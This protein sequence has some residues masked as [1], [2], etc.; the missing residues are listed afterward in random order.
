MKWR[1]ALAAAIATACLACSGDKPANGRPEP[2]QGTVPGAAPGVRT[3]AALANGEWPMPTGDYGNLRYSPLSAINT[4]NVKN[5]HPV[6]TMSTGV[7]CF[8]SGLGGTVM[9]ALRLLSV[10]AH[11]GVES[12]TEHAANDTEH[13]EI[14]ARLHCYVAVGGIRGFE[15]DRPIAVR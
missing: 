4:T 15:H 2:P 13:A 6:T 9:P 11:V 1:L 14:H 5:L 10:A 8:S 3:I 7:S 12:R